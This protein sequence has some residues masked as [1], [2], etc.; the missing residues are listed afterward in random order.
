MVEPI[1][2]NFSHWDLLSVSYPLRSK[3]ELKAL[4]EGDFVKVK[5][6]VDALRAESGQPPTTALDQTLKERKK[7]YVVF[8]HATSFR[9]LIRSN[10]SKQQPAGS[11]RLPTASISVGASISTNVK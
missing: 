1:K 11:G 2:S 9:A 7:G 3:A 8:V 10:Y 5:C 6:E 4:S